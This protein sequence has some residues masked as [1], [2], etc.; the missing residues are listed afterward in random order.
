MHGEEFLCHAQS[1]VRHHL[2]AESSV[3]HCTSRR[4]EANKGNPGENNK[5][6]KHQGMAIVRQTSAPNGLIS[7]K[8][9]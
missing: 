9:A 1:P 6:R 2:G 5:S 3:R 4:M 8:Q 7:P